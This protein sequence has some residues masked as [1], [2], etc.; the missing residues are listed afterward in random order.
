MVPCAAASF[1]DYPVR[2]AGDYA[3]F[4]EKSGLTIAAH[5]VDNVRDQETYFGAKLIRKGYLPIF[6]VMRN[7]SA[8]DSFLLKKDAVKYRVLDAAAAKV[9]TPE[10]RS[11]AG[12]TSVIADAALS[13]IGAVGGTIAGVGPIGNPLPLESAGLKLI[14]TASEVQQNLLKK[15]L[16]SKTLSPGASAWGFLYVGVPKD[17]ARRIHLRIPF[18]RVGSDDTIEFDLAPAYDPEVRF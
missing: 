14:S 6:I 16:Q 3:T 15:E 8:S 4:V 9:P 18:M 17:S 7:A 1:P 12:E 10:I 13:T 11:K 2:A 5:P